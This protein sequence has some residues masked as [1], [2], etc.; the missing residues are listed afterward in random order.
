MDTLDCRALR[1]DGPAGLCGAS[2]LLFLSGKGYMLRKAIIA[3]GAFLSLFLLWFAIHDYREAGPIAEENLRGLALSMDAAIENLAVHDPTLTQL[4]KYHPEDLAYFALIDRRG[5]YRFHSN[6]DLIGTVADD[7]GPS[8]EP[9]RT[10]PSEERISLGTGEKA[11]QFSTPLYLPGETLQLRLTLH[12]YRA[13][14]VIRRARLNATIL[15]ALLAAGWLLAAGLWRYA[16][17]EEL[18]QLEMARKESLAKL[19][20]MGAM[21]AHEI[22]NPLSGIKGFAQVIAKRPTEPRN[23]GFAQN[24]VTESIRLEHLVTDLLA[25][26]SGAPP[27]M[28]TVD[29]CP[30][31]RQVA[32]LLAPDLRDTGVEVLIQCPEA[33]TVW[34][35]GERL[36]Q[37]L[38]NLARNALQAMPQGGNLAIGAAQA[39]G[40]ALVT[41]E[42]SGAGIA[43]E[44]L[45]RIFEPFFTTKARGTGLGLALSRKIVEEHGGAIELRSVV[46]R[47]TTVTLRLPLTNND[48]RRSR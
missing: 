44:N 47:G 42:D 45:S 7:P 38:L 25:Y 41:V 16:R 40:L 21:L 2:G 28:S 26:A 33:L 5:V 43:E 29:L 27:D 13:D 8:R 22:R 36:E 9:S 1:A 15:L 18:L 34:G 20:E 39:G 37:L 14:A 35:S 12:T 10:S 32:S 3:A 30:L 19:G 48:S 6:P 17:R 23:E 31:I 11:F 24:I 4:S 46:D